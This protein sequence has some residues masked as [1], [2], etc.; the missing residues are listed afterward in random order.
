MVAIVTD[1]TSDLPIDI[2]E[3]KNIQIVPL[4]IVWGSESLIDGVEITGQQFYERLRTSEMMPGTS[5]PTPCE[6]AQA[7][8]RISEEQNTDEIVCITISKKLSGTYESA[9]QAA[10]ELDLKIKVVDSTFTSM[11]L[12]FMA[13]QACA[14]RDQGANAEEIAA[15][16]PARMPNIN[17][18]FTVATL[19]FL[20][21][22]G[23]IGKARH[24]LGTALQIKPILCVD[25]GL[26]ASAGSVRTRKKAIQKV[27]ELV[28][29]KTIHAPAT[30]I[31]VLQGDAL[32][33][34][35]QLAIDAQK[36]LNPS[37]FYRSS[38]SSVIGAHTGP[39]VIGIAYDANP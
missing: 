31:A 21:R 35:N 13:L 25:E 36:A 4:H 18:Y 8:K 5:Q 30:R 34:A 19:D 11:A 1:S 15:A 23:R 29:E 24:I 22:G 6:F 14:L 12:G 17:I 10:T 3:E 33:E 16:L 9:V 37:V 32:E 28:Q 7:F 27:I 39:G 2:V 38:V 20:H 26:A